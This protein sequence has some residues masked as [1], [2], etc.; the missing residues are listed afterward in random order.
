MLFALMIFPRLMESVW[1]W[2]L[3][4]SDNVYGDFWIGLG[5]ILNVLWE[6][7]SFRE[8]SPPQVWT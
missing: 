6:A 2:W 3:E 8:H 5:Y 7:L 4:F 1:Y